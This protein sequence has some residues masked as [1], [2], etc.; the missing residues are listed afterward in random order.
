MQ[1]FRLIAWCESAT[2]L[3]RF[4]PDR[5]AVYQELMDHLQERRDAFMEQGLDER[6]AT[7]KALDAMGD[8][9][10]LA[11][12]LAA[13][14][15]PFWGYFLRVARIIL[16]ILLVL[17]LK[18]IRNYIKDLHI[19]DRPVLSSFDFFDA[20]S[21][22]G[23]SGRTLL[24][25]SQPDVSFSSDGSTFTLTDAIVYT[26]QSNDI[27]MHVLIRQETLLPW[28][29]HDGYFTHFSITGWFRARDSLGNIYK[30]F[31]EQ[32]NPNAP[33]LYSWSVQSGLFAGTHECWINDLSPEA[34]WVEIYYER[35]GRSYSLRV[36]LTGGGAK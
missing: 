17:S 3:I 24:Q 14:H 5:K 27:C 11:P 30:G 34:K 33:T 2:N 10:E 13:I 4:G 9:K 29:E 20:A 15:R 32:K 21:Y 35:D 36:D 7:T 12:Q 8:A 22:T 16:V 1:R 18:P 6:E 23:D 28:T 26:T 31:E 25:L 19:S